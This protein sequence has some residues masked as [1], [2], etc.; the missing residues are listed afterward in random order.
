MGYY[1]KKL[2]GEIRG[3]YALLVLVIMGMFMVLATVGV[4]ERACDAQTTAKFV[5]RSLVKEA[6]DARS[7]ALWDA[8][9]SVCTQEQ[10]DAIAARLKPQDPQILGQL[11]QWRKT[12]AGWGYD[13]KHA[14]CEALDAEIAA[15]TDK[16]KPKD[17]DPKATPE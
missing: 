4:V 11:E 17:T 7:D 1:E 3:A 9:E 5:D 16:I 13:D 10:C 2:K 8:L 6:A 12:L 14:L 15:I